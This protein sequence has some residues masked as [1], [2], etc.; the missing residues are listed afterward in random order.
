[1]TDPTNYTCL[2]TGIVPNC[3]ICDGGIS[4]CQKCNSNAATLQFLN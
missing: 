1:M 4:K 2:K 3:I